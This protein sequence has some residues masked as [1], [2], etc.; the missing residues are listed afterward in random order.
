MTTTAEDIAAQKKMGEDQ[1]R[2][3][4]AMA[5]KHKELLR[6]QI[7]DLDTQIAALQ[8]QRSKASSDLGKL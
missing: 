1:V 8:M 3:A 6:K 5:S 7:S 2:A 4:S